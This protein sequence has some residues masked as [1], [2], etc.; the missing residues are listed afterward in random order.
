Y[1][2]VRALNVGRNPGTYW[3][4]PSQGGT[5][6]EPTLV[7]QPSFG[8]DE[9][10]EQNYPKGTALYL[11]GYPV[12]TA[13]RVE[14]GGEKKAIDILDQLHLKIRFR[15]AKTPVKDGPKYQVVGWELI[16][17]TAK[18]RMVQWTY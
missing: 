6:D 16:D 11:Q 1:G 10:A 2:M 9:I 12:G 14:I 15:R 17:G 5:T 3:G 4:A 13:Y 18:H 8:Y 7:V